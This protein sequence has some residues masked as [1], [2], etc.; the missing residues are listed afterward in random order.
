MMREI[1]PAG[2]N[3][4]ASPRTR[5][6]DRAVWT[7]SVLP[8]VYYFGHREPRSVCGSSCMWRALSFF[9]FLLTTAYCV[10]L[11]S[12]LTKM[13][14]NWVQVGERSW[15]ANIAK[16]VVC[17]VSAAGVWCVCLLTWLLG[18]EWHKTRSHAAYAFS[19]IA[20]AVAQEASTQ[21]ATVGLVACMLVPVSAL[22]LGTDFVTSVAV[23]PFTL[24][25]FSVIWLAPLIVS[26]YGRFATSAVRVWMDQYGLH[27][28]LPRTERDSAST[29]DPTPLDE[30]LLHPDPPTAH[31]TPLILQAQ[32]KPFSA[33][34]EAART[35]YIKISRAM[36][37]ESR[38]L[39]F[40][41]VVF[42]LCTMIN[43]LSGLMFA[44][45][46]AFTSTEAKS[47][48][49]SAKAACVDDA[50]SCT[51]YDSATCPYPAPNLHHDTQCS[52]LCDH[53]GC[54]AYVHCSDC[55]NPHSVC[56]KC[57]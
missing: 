44:Y 35:A 49:V 31:L 57:M 55:T 41:F 34:T 54:T 5:W 42:C 47:S 51:A 24:P 20:H 15:G 3:A 37:L 23:F 21:V 52:H 6:G 46:L 50:S 38:A 1:Q 4:T 12:A 19:S 28:L 13:C 16:F 36:L 27:A 17:C 48:E 22:V 30:P 2:A 14:T 26:S 7:L 33:S 9:T 39:L 11:T 45:V 25:F 18:R 56:C 40:P 10:M 53:D 8:G 29:L 43:G 32:A